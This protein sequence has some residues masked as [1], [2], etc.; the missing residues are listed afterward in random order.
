[1]FSSWFLTILTMKASLRILNPDDYAKSRKPPAYKK[2]PVHSLRSNS[3]C[4]AAA[5]YDN[6]FFFIYSL[7][8]PDSKSASGKKES[9]WPGKAAGFRRPERAARARARRR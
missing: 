2:Y 3:A 6:F 9:G 7:L 4:G 5:F 8:T 1:M